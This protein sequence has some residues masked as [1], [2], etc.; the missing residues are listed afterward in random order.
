VLT[1]WQRFCSGGS[2]RRSMF[3]GGRLLSKNAY[4]NP[5]LLLRPNPE[6]VTSNIIDDGWLL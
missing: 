6:D 5:E 3:H 2:V 1:G 4:L